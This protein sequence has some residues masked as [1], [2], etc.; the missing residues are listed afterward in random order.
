MYSNTVDTLTPLVGA[1]DGT[2][3]EVD[4]GFGAYGGGA[5]GPASGV[6][7]WVAY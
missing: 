7:C 1:P 3:N 6:N 2:A 5:D 4:A